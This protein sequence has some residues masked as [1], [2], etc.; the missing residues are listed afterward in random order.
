MTRP[1]PT[2]GTAVGAAPDVIGLD[3]TGIVVPDLEQALAFYAR[4]FGAVLVSREHD[5]EVD[6]EAIGLPGERVRLRGAILRVGGGQLELH[7]YL[8]PRG[9]GVR[10]VCD[11]GIGHVA[12]AV[13]D[14]DRACERLGS[15]GIRFNSRPVTIYSG[16]R[17]G[18]RWVYGR[19]PWG[20]V[21]ELCQHPFDDGVM[22]RHLM[23]RH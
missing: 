23:D 18:R 5:T 10:R 20:V 6:A 3:H 19:D 14:I 1:E 22:D 4:A 21:I 12:F 11:T 7:E 8:T 9:T 13:T 16:P 15:A 17:K 2:P